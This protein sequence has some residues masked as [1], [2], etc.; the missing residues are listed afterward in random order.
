[1]TQFSTE[2]T[3]VSTKPNPLSRSRWLMLLLT[4]MLA[5]RAMTLAYIGRAGSSTVGA[6]PA[7]WLMPLIGDAVIGVTALAV[8]YLI[9]RGRGLGA[10][11]TIIVWN[12]LAIWDALSAF[13]IHL[14]NPWPSF[15]MIET[16]GSSMFFIA[17]MMHVIILILAWQPGVKANFLEA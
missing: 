15:F 8:A 7:A 16:F 3:A 17:S 14:T 13:I 5:G 9:F 6:P 1:M 11:V 12:A 2:S 10:W 4:L